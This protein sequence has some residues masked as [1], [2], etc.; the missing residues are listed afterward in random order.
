MDRQP[1]SWLVVSTVPA[2]QEKGKGVQA[3][4]LSPGSVASVG[5][6]RPSTQATQNTRSAVA[7]GEAVAQART[8]RRWGWWR[9]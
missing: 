5:R 6:M 3:P 1:H 2:T 9:L 7:W 8:S 4:S